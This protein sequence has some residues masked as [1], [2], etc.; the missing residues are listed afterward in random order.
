[1][2][3]T[4]EFD[5]FV[6][7]N[8]L[9]HA[10]VERIGQALKKRHLTVFLDRWELVPGRS[11]P[12]ALEGHLRQCHSAAVVLGPN[13]MGPWQQREHYLALDRQAR[14]PSFGV[15]PVILPNADP[16]LGF[17][18]LNTWVDLRHG[19]D[20]AQSIDLLA[21]AVRGEPPSALLERTRRATAEVCPYRGLEVFR[22]EDAPFFFGREAFTER[23]VKAVAAGS[24]VAVVGA[25]GSG[26]SSVVRAGLVPRLRRHDG[27]KVWEVVTLIP[28]QQ[29][30]QALAGALLPLL[31]PQMT[32]TD[33]LVE[34]NKQA[35]HLAA[36][37]LRLAQV[38]R[39]VLEKQRG[40]DRL[41][42]VVDQ[43]E[44]LYTRRILDQN[45]R[46]AHKQSVTRFIDELL[47]ATDASPLSV[48]LTLR[49]DFYGEAISHRGLSD[50]LQEGPVNL[51]PM[52]PEELKQAVTQPAEKVGLG[53][54]AGLVDRLL[55]DVGDEPGNL[56]L[57]EFAL[58]K[59]WSARGGN[60]LMH[61]VYKTMG[62]VKGAIAKR[63]EE[64]FTGLS[65]AEQKT[66]ERL[67][68]RLVRPGDETGDTRR[69]AELGELDAAGQALARTLAGPEIRLLITGRDPV[70]ERETVEVAHEALIREWRQLCDWVGKVRTTLKHQSLLE[71]MVKSWKQDRG[72]LASGR[73]LR[74]FRRAGATTEQAAS[75]LR[76]SIKR[77]LK[78]R[79]AI[80]GGVL[81][82]LG[83]SGGFLWWSNALGLSPDKG[84]ELLLYRVGAY[85]PAWIPDMVAIPPGRFQMGSPAP[86]VDPQ[87]QDDER[88]AHEVT[89]EKGFHI[90]KYEVIFEQYCAS[91]HHAC[92]SDSQWGRGNQP[93]I[94]VTWY[95]AGEYAAWLSQATGQAFRL[96]S[97]AE[98]EYAARA[99]TQTRWS[100]GDQES[101]LGNYAWFEGNSGAQTHPVG[102]KKPNPWGLYDVHGNVWE[103]VEDCW[104]ESYDEAPTDGSAWL[105]ENG[106]NCDP[107]ALRGG[108]WFDG[109]GGA[110]SAVRF[111]SGPSSRVS[112]F[113]FRVLCSSPIQ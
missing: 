12:D 51:A 67:F 60:Q 21:A 77:Q 8:S 63:A 45:E 102:E 57:L 58:K 3:V 76:A 31:E 80:A 29:P 28:G 91:T 79:A 26:K 109:P 92:P 7:Y 105:E 38:I 85:R 39:R 72:G 64:V 23:L 5:V 54:E 61:H 73:Q 46:A 86:D 97:E 16:A 52:T 35:G 78:I 112:S 98:W 75:F 9:D 33:R 43:W 99:G 89:F 74:D 101:D 48:V 81:L 42:L 18:S 44:E 110:R 32:E 40:T 2:T 41:L 69:R 49:A 19:V 107:R 84:A 59:L 20:D 94:N 47:S 36:G 34:I 30:L 88:L 22:E 24:L 96:P 4:P 55:D 93:V 62:G 66:A 100:F 1:M 104:H 106:G 83:G 65:A 11:W 68:T 25:S 56:P 15:I 95:E 90:G 87:A 70:T 108:S 27:G 53:F 10:A 111:R 6:S 113:G 37:E 103:W 71:D 17:L 14:D 82:V 13:G 50:R